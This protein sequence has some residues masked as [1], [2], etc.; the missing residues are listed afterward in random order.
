MLSLAACA[1]KS[2][3][4]VISAVFNEY[5][6]GDGNAVSQSHRSSF[7]HSIPSAAAK[8]LAPSGMPRVVFSTGTLIPLGAGLAAPEVSECQP[9][10]AMQL[11]KCPKQL[12]ESFSSVKMVVPFTSKQYAL[13]ISRDYRNVTGDGSFSPISSPPR[14]TTG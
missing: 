5:L 10:V 11:A 14:P 7:L 6:A 8:T 3:P 9:D 4:A 2:S 13:G 1:A 12:S